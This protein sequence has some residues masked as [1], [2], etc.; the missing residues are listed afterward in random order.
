MNNEH[1]Q[2]LE[3]MY[4]A[5]PINNFYNPTINVEEC[6]SEIILTI[7][8]DFFHSANAVHGSVYFKMLDDAAFFAE[9]LLLKMFLC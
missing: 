3:N 8:E 2:K 4:L 1:Y 7:K 9:T 5:A 6:N